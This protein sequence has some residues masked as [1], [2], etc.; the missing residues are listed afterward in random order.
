METST[1]QEVSKL[2]LLPKPI[3]DMSD[4][5]LEAWFDTHIRAERGKRPGKA[6]KASTPKASSTPTTPTEE[7]VDDYA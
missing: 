2:T 5:E 7:N 4:E 6:R 3:P 1:E